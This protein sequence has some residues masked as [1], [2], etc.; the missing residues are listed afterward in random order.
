M[1]KKALAILKK[2]YL[3]YEPK[4]RPSDA[5]KEN[6]IK[7]GVYVPES[8]MTHDEIVTEIKALSERISVESVA[9]AFLYSLSS[10][11]LKYRTALSSLI[12][13]RSLPTHKLILKDVNEYGRRVVSCNVCGCVHGLEKQEN[14][15]WNEYGVFHY[16]SPID[17]GRKP[18]FSCAEYVLNDLRAFEK[19][20]EVEPR[21]E[22][23]RI[24]N[25]I[26][27]CAKEMKSHNMDTALVSEIRKRRF[28]SATGNGI[29]C[30]LGTLAICDVFESSEH[31]GF[32]HSFTNA[33]D[34]N[35]RRDG[36]TFYPLYYWR[37][38]NGVNYDAVNEIFGSF[39]GDKLSHERAW[40]PLDQAA[41]ATKKKA[42][43]NAES[44]FTPGVYV[45]MLTD[46]ERRYLAL[47]PIDPTWETA[48]MYSATYEWKKRTVLFFDRDTIVKAIHE[49]YVVEE[50]GSYRW[51]DYHEFDTRLE[52]INRTTLIPLTSKGRQKPVNPSSVMAINPFGCY[53]LITLK[54]ND[55]SITVRNFRNNQTLEIGEEKRI[56]KI[57]TDTDFHEFMR[58][59]ITSCPNNYFERTAEVRNMS[60][61]TVEFRPGD[62]FR[63]QVDRTHYAY[64]LILGKTRELEKWSELPKEHSF[65]HLLT[66]P[67]IVRM[68]DF[69]TPDKNLTVDDLKDKPLRTPGYY[70][71]ND[72]IWGRH[73]IVAHKRL[74]LDDIQFVISVSGRSPFVHSSAEPDLLGRLRVEWGFSFVEIPW[75]EAPERMRSEISTWRNFT[76]GVSLSIE[77]DLC[78][79][80]LEE[81]LKDRPG[82][83]IQHDLALPE[84]RDKFNF[85]MTFLGLPENCTL[86]EFAAKFG[87]LSRQEYIDLVEKRCK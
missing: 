69:I 86:D 71:D 42:R 58:F 13:A 16:F 66:M 23:Y 24:L 79:K 51:Q 38:K 50:D 62:I 26:F 21:D 75:D 2:N 76:K 82:H 78:G 32:L 41:S 29:H 83:M 33:G 4:E 45:V 7:R 1:D 11:D 46:E 39:C 55:S 85:L 40:I 28:F 49:E 8:A 15:D 3:P 53:L 61:Q 9:K 36:L 43:S 18:N 81:I 67:L 80:S 73:K 35:V 56:R 34:F 52:T 68:Y 19:A 17:Y 84:N 20:S 48:I 64:G 70:S 30:I 77:G 37:G 10:G 74:T 54:N 72:I 65:R 87:G 59:Y 47:N 22:D 31:R 27:A 63:C 6:A 12:W 25:G 14:I 5:E 44:Y 57:M 60:H